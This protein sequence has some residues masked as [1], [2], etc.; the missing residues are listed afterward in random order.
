M[1]QGEIIIYK[2]TDNPDFE[3]EVRVEEET[4]WLNR[5]QLVILFERDVKL[6]E[7]ILEML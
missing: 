5:Q 7:N 2:S 1:Q 3:I 6:L 4:V